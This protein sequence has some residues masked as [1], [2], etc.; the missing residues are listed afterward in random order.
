[1]NETETLRAALAGMIAVLDNV[2][3]DHPEELW[4]GSEYQT[5]KQALVAPVE[6]TFEV[7]RD[8]EGE[9]TLYMTCPCGYV[10]EDPDFAET[11]CQRYYRLDSIDEDNGLTLEDSGNTSDGGE[12]YRALCG[13]PSG[14]S[15]LHE[16]PES[17][18]IVDF[19]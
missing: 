15:R 4:L 6:A 17:I 10:T 12:G 2:H 16:L 5:A 1:M 11:G 19:S 18:Q 8:E 7:R 14:C 13:S 9:P 3:R